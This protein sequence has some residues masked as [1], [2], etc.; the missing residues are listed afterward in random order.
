MLW[1][2]VAPA[3]LAE[4]GHALASH[5]EV[6]FA[7]AISGQANIV[8]ATLRPGNGDLSAYLSAIS[9]GPGGCESMPE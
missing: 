8:A 2:T 9:V 6:R 3:A 1:L 4:V 7:A 5:P